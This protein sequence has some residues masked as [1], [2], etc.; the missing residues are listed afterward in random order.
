MGA[1]Q[2]KFSPSFYLL[3][4]R[5]ACNRTGLQKALARIYIQVNEAFN[6]LVSCVLSPMR[7]LTSATS[8]D[9]LNPAVVFTFK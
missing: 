1:S 8:L 3:K 2:P 6:N 7:A 5:I 4:Y 9:Q